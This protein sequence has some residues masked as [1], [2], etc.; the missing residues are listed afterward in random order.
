MFTVKFKYNLKN[1]LN[2]LLVLLDAF[3]CTDNVGM[4][5]TH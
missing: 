5:F 2:I 3:Q 4:L 1:K